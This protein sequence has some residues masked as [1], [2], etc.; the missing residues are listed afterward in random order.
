MYVARPRLYISYTRHVVPL[1]FFTQ[2]R[3]TPPNNQ[4][5]PLQNITGH[6][7][8]PGRVDIPFIYTVSRTHTGDSYAWR[9]VSA[10]QNGNQT[11]SFIATISFKRAERHDTRNVPIAHQSEPTTYLREKYA[12]VLA[13]KEPES[14]PAAPSLD[15]LVWMGKPRPE[16]ST[17]GAWI[18]GIDIRKVDMGPYNGVVGE[19]G[20]GRVGQWRQLAFYRVI[21]DDDDDDDDDDEDEDDTEDAEHDEDDE[22][23]LHISAHLYA[24]DRNSLFLFQHAHGYQSRETRL[25]SLGHTVV[26]HGDVERLRM[27]DKGTGGSGRRRRRRRR[28]FVQEAWTS[29]SGDNRGCHESLLW[30]WEKGEVVATTLQDGMVRVSAKK[31]V[32][33]QVGTGQD[34]EGS[35]ERTREGRA[36]RAPRAEMQ[37]DPGKTVVKAKL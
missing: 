26:F 30:D 24:S 25:G 19:G 16:G 28:W 35:D 31:P 1:L 20:D 3:G 5:Q 17:A 37:G 34:G 36:R 29:N 32:A 4:R 12:S 10:Y 14:H 8:L 2:S 15:A 18:P 23:R 6:F 33:G 9:Q 7:I 13:G 22:L 27:V 21:L 11:P